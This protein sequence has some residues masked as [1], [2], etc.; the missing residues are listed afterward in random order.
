MGEAISTMNENVRRQRERYFSSLFHHGQ[1]ESQTETQPRM[2]S[3]PQALSS[4]GLAS[5]ADDQRD[6]PYAREAQII[7]DE[8]LARRLQEEENQ[9]MAEEQ[10]GP[11]ALA[12]PRGPRGFERSL[13]RSSVAG[14]QSGPAVLSESD[15]EEDPDMVVLR[16]SRRSQDPRERMMMSMMSSGSPFDFLLRQLLL[17][18]PMAQ[19]YPRGGRMSGE[20]QRIAM[21]DEPSYEA[22]LRLGDLLGE[23]VDRGATKEAIDG[24]SL[25]FKVDS[26][27]SL[28]NQDCPVCLDKF[29]EGQEVRTLQCFHSFH[30]DCIDQWLKNIKNCP[31]CK[32]DIDADFSLESDQPHQHVSSSSSS[33]SSAAGRQ[34]A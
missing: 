23:S 24:H 27:S 34:R 9:G 7:D 22:L 6:N 12:G 11:Q 10:R 29:Q 2:A 15:D 13:N 19:M 25:K 31:V 3:Q 26:K 14:G 20:A 32:V 8:Q 30:A 1:P 17:G 28:K 4:T 21:D 33:S 18:V 16:P 5:H